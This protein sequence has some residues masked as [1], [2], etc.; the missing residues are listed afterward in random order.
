MSQ[1]TTIYGLMDED[2]LRKVVGSHENDNELAEWVEYYLG[3]E[4]VHRSAHVT[5]KQ[6][7]EYKFEQ[8]LFH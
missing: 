7:H 4:L 5:L 1:I 8:G 6:G 2:K 3:E